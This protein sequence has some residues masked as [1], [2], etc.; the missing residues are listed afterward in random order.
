MKLY[1]NLKNNKGKQ[2][3]FGGEG[4]IIA[5]LSFKNQ[6]VGKIGLYAI[7]TGTGSK[8]IG[9]RV[10]WQ[11]DKTPRNGKIISENVDYKQ[12]SKR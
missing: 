4:C 12:V 9:Y 11:D 3:G 10:V 8:V 5:D 7:Y 6:W 1:A 2:G